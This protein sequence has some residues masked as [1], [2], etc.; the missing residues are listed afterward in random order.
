MDGEC[1]QLVRQAAKGIVEHTGIGRDLA[2]GMRLS[3]ELGAWNRSAL[4]SARVGMV[5]RSPV[6]CIWCFTEVGNPAGGSV[7]S[8]SSGLK[9]APCKRHKFNSK[10]RARDT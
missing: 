4:P 3:N 10:D 8:C 7:L 6:H 9:A 2:I 1:C 5:E